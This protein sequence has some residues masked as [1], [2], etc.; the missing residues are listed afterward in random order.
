MKKILLVFIA[1]ALAACGSNQTAG[2]SSDGVKSAAVAADSPKVTLQ[3]VLATMETARYKEGEVLV[4]YKPGV[5]A[6]ASKE[7]QAVGAQSL[8]KLFLINAEHLILPQG[9]SVK[10]AITAFMA[11]PNV[12]Y[13]E[14]NYLR[15]TKSTFPND[16]YFNPQQWALNNTGKFAG[17]TAGADMKMPQAW[18][19]LT[20]SNIVVAVIDS[21]IDFNHPDLVNNIWRNTA[22]TSCTD[23][24]D[25]DG[26]GYIDDCQGWNFAGKNNNPM[27]DEGHGT[28]VAGIIGAAGNNGVGISGVMWNVRLMPLKFIGKFGPSVCGPGENFCGSLADEIAAIQY[29]VRGGASVINA[30][31]GGPGFA[32]SEMDAISAANTAGVLFIASAGNGG[33]DGNGDNNDLTPEYPANYNV[34]NIIT[35]AATDQNDRRAS[36]S[37]FG[38]K[39]VHVAAPGVYIL[40][41]ITPGLTFSLCTGTAAAGYDFCDGTSMAAP[42]V[43]GLAGLLRSYYGHFSHSQVRATILRYVDVNPTL[44]GWIMTGGRVNAY[45]A[46]SSLLPPTNL[47]AKADSSGQITITWTDNATGEDGYYVE[48]KAGSGDFVQIASIAANSGSYV[49]TGLSASTAYTYRVRAFNTIPAASVFSNEASATTLAASSTSETSGGG[50]GCSIGPRKNSRN[51][52]GDAAVMLMPLVVVFVLRAVKRRKK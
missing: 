30:S 14:P 22:E 41:T 43:A 36:F 8:R 20:G 31:F 9:V 34:P 10:N 15:Y 40:S 5:S 17:G 29:A 50:G 19:I 46:L 33:K 23:G 38:P 3:S 7:G 27:D 42:H 1:L 52:F 48:R 35:V 4:K 12:E 28:H 47:A 32:Q 11:D 45:R 2:L 37:N 26:N 24:V 18:D 51:A 16:L 25:N 21:G 6:P 13:A 39:T 44:Q 49:D